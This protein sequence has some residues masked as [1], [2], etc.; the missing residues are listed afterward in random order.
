MK[1]ENR[2]KEERLRAG[3]TQRKLSEAL[4]VSVTAISLWENGRA[5]PP[6]ERMIEMAQLYGCTLD[7]LVGLGETREAG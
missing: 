7:W 4:D 5:K 3:L 6:L 2:I 1:V